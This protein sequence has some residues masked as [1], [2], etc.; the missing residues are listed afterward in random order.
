MSINV[1]STA[2]AELNCIGKLKVIGVV[3][4]LPI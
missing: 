2:G 4:P 3:D 1:N